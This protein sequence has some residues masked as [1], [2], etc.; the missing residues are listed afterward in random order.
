MLTLKFYPSSGSGS[1]EGEK[2]DSKTDVVYDGQEGKTGVT[3][4]Y[5]YEYTD[6]DEDQGQ[7]RTI[8]KIEKLL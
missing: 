5:E 3:K 2:V 8:I 6:P 1:G 7:Q 4:K